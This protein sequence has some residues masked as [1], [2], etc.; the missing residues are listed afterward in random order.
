MKTK[1]TPALIGEIAGRI[2][3]GSAPTTSLRL[4]GIGAM[5][6]ADIQNRMD[7]GQATDLERELSS[8]VEQA[9][10]EVKSMLEAI[11]IAAAASDPDAA[12]WWLERRFPA[13]YGAGDGRKAEGPEPPKSRSPNRSCKTN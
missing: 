5:Q 6:W 1:L 12:R 9:E 13:E 4:A 7:G 3:F 2:R 10:A 11:V 8:A